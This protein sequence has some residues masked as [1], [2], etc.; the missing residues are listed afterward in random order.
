MLN[1]ETI[2][3]KAP[4]CSECE[5]CEGYAFICDGSLLEAD[6][7]CKNYIP[8]DWQECNYIAGVWYKRKIGDSKNHHEN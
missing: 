7:S 4:N 3:I 2:S 5:N 8:N 6:G 1:K